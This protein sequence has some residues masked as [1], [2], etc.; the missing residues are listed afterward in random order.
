MIIYATSGAKTPLSYQKAFS[1]AFITM[2]AQLTIRNLIQDAKLSFTLSEQDSVIIEYYQHEAMTLATQSPYFEAWR[3]LLTFLD[4]LGCPRYLESEVTQL[5]MIEAPYLFASCCKG[6]LVYE[7]MFTR[8]VPSQETIYNIRLLHCMKGTPGFAKLVGIVTDKHTTQVKSFLIEFPRARNRLDHFAQGQPLSWT[9]RER[10]AIQL[11]ECVSAAHSKGFVIGS[12]LIPGPTVVTE[13]TDSILIWKFKNQFPMGANQDLFYPPEFQHY[14]YASKGTNE[15]DSG[16]IT[17]KTDLYHLGL[18]LWFLAENLPRT[19]FSPVCMRNKCSDE[20]NSKCD[21]SHSNPVALP[22]LS[23]D[24]PQYYKDIVSACRAENPQ[25][26]VCVKTL[27]EWCPPLPQYEHLPDA[28]NMDITAIE[29]ALLKRIACDICRLHCGKIFFHC[30]VCLMGDF[31]ICNRC[32]E[33]GAHC[34]DKEHLL[35]QNRMI[36]SWTVPWKYHSSV[37]DSGTREI[38]EL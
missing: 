14:R 35:E 31:D 9:R 23:T 20:L 32:Y 7:N 27:L 18:L 22:E 3:E 24:I 38:I 16:D 1:L 37:N 2:F 28:Q 17:T 8:P 21:D 29:N 13:G 10:W 12:L 4:D 30:S 25:D 11:L 6:M 5:E 34:F 26:R 19:H 15:A 33:F 36:G